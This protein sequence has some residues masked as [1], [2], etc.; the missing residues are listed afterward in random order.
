LGEGAEPAL[1]QTLADDPSME[2][3]ARVS[4]LLER[5]E[6]AHP[7]R[8]EGALELLEQIGNSEACRL[9]AALAPGHR[10]PV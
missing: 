1:L 5:L 10:V 4:Q 9:L 8:R 7:W 2:M 3:R 6:G